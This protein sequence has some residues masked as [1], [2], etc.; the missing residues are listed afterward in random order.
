MVASRSLVAEQVKS[1]S[2]DGRSDIFTFGILLY[3]SLTGVHPFARPNLNSTYESIINENPPSPVSY[4]PELPEL[5][6]HILRKMLAKAPEERYQSAHE[7]VTDLKELR[8]PD[9]HS[10]SGAHVA[11]TRRRSLLGILGVSLVALLIILISIWLGQR[12]GQEN[13]SLSE[14]VL[15][16]WPSLE[17]EAKISP[18]GRWLSFLSQQK[19]QMVL[20]K[21]N[22]EAPEADKVDIRGR[23]ISHAWSS[24]GQR[25]VCLARDGPTFRLEIVPA[26]YR[27]LP[28]LLPSINEMASEAR[29]DLANSATRVLARIGSHIS[30]G[31][32]IRMGSRR[33]HPDLQ[34]GGHP[35]FA[36]QT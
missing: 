17:T 14:E 31:I 13:L 34:A 25:I 35:R 30:L 20:F 6:V 33:A 16:G 22:I 32:E 26:M 11:G 23:P 2:V 36:T 3:E 19:D 8:E 9:S 10:W 21:R 15:V 12:P 27:D 1:G 7:I 4:R 29:E 5:L 28:K 18:D 24:D